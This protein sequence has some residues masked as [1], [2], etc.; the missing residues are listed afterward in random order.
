MKDFLEINKMLFKRTIF[1]LYYNIIEIILMVGLMFIYVN[2]IMN[3]NDYI[4]LDK[5][6]SLLI[7]LIDYIL[8]TIVIS[9]F[10][11]LLKNCVEGKTFKQKFVKGFKMIFISVSYIMMIT[12][13]GLLVFKTLSHIDIKVGYIIYMYLL[14]GIYEL[15]YIRHTKPREIFNASFEFLKNNLLFYISNTIIPMIIFTILYFRIINGEYNLFLESIYFIIIAV[16]FI[17]R[18]YIYK[19]LSISAKNKLEYTKNLYGK[20]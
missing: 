18:G 19:V 1:S 11:Y 5:S 7:L 8:R 14:I 12:Y 15:I 17:Y 9:V 20:C 13:I 10:F 2:F 6:Y 4:K 16:L 3:F